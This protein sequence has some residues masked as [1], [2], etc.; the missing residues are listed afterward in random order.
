MLTDIQRVASEAVHKDTVLIVDDSP[1]NLR[2]LGDVLRND[3]QVRAANSGAKG[4]QAAHIHPKPD[5]I[6]L[7]VMMPDMDGYQVLKR[8]KE[9]REL[10]EIPVIFVTSMSENEDEQFGLE[11]GAV[12]YITKPINSSIVKVRVKNHLELK[13]ARDRLSRQNHWLEQEVE[14]RMRENEIVRD[15][16]V[17]TLAC[18]AEER[19]NETG[20]H[21]VRTQTYV[22]L[23]GRYLRNFTGYEDALTPDRL[24]AIVR[25]APLH[26]IGKVGVPDAILQKPARLT[27]DEFEVMKTH[28]VIGAHAIERAIEIV[29]DSTSEEARSHGEDAYTFL[30][31]AKEIAYGHH[32]RWDG[33]GYPQGLA[34]EAIPVSAR[35]MAVA[36]VF[37]ALTTKRVYKDAISCEEAADIIEA[38][39]GSHFDP[40]VVHAFIAC[41]AQFFEAAARLADEETAPI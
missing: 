20:L 12:D 23:L 3:Y 22:Q 7:D 29:N 38:D 18:L 37:D 39:S 28:T 19:D 24:E 17:R 36:D 16:T 40:N 30:N 5:L 34:G 35:L 14:H 1:E 21:I 13:R 32:E 2:L 4:L 25:A 9:D 15:L 27:D 11:M 31:V 6:L 33:T 10:N 41:R 8:L 26:D